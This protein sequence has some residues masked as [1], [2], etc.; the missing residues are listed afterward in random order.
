MNCCISSRCY[1]AFSRK[2]EARP[3]QLSYIVVEEDRGIVKFLKSLHPSLV[4]WLL[5]SGYKEPGYW[6]EPAYWGNKYKDGSQSTH[7]SSE[8]QRKTASGGLV[9]REIVKSKKIE[10]QCDRDCLYWVSAALF[11][12]FYCWTSSQEQLLQGLLA[13]AFHLIAVKFLVSSLS[14]SFCYVYLLEL[15]WLSKSSL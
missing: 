7:P 10:G 4:G 11:K 13:R 2:V 6:Q 8:H 12:R 1:S 9:G 5:I 3:L 15:T 14:N